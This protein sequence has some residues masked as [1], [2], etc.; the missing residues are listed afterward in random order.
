MRIFTAINL[1]EAAKSVLEQHQEELK[2]RLNFPVK[3]VDKKSFH[4]TLLFFGYLNQK[5]LEKL[6]SEAEKKAKETPSFNI[7]LD[8]ICYAPPGKLPRMI[9]AMGKADRDLGIVPHVTL[10]RMDRPILDELPLV[11]EDIDVSFKVR[12]IDVMKSILKKEGPEYEL[13][14]S[15]NLK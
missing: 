10:C 1:P 8:K 13:L 15:Y 12:K 14:A 2:K 4:I 7:V 9:W 3:W 6:L 11:E 5:G